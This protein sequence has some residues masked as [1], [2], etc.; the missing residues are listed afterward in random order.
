MEPPVPLVLYAAGSA[1]LPQQTPSFWPQSSDSLRMLFLLPAAVSSHLLTSEP[2]ELQRP[3]LLLPNQN[4]GRTWQIADGVTT[5]MAST[6]KLSC[7]LFEVLHFWLVNVQG[8]HDIS[9]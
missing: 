3:N 9:P 1:F 7:S 5:S 6:L 4:T 8:L 2:T